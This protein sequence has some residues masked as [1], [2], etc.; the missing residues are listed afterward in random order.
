MSDQDANSEQ[1]DERLIRAL[2]VADQAPPVITAG[3]D[4]A[5]AD[6]STRHFASRRW[7]WKRHG[8]WALA[9]S[10]AL[11]A[12]L[13][14]QTI[15]PAS[16]DAEVLYADVNGSGAIDIADVFALARADQ[17]GV[18]QADLDAFAMRVVS[19]DAGGAR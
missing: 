10:V 12:V 5:L 13:A 6:I 1:L 9:A 15:G 3:V 7:G 2:T 11:V 19:L 4:R 14:V 18:T 8:G 17:P 16:D